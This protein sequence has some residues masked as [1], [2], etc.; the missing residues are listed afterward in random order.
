[1]FNPQLTEEG[2]VDPLLRGLVADPM[3]KVDTAVVD[4]LRNF[5]FGQPGEGGLDL[6]ALNI[7]REWRDHGLA[8][9]NNVREAYGLPRIQDFSEMTRDVELAQK[10]RLLYGSVEN[11]DLWVA[12]LCGGHG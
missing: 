10:L 6:V 8:S 11:I 9:Y 2:G 3:Q 12:G 5:L 1:M 4:D 7:Q